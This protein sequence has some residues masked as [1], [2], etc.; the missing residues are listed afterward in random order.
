MENGWKMKYGWS[1]A[2]LSRAVRA[3]N[4]EKLITDLSSNS[5][6]SERIGPRAYRFYYPDLNNIRLT[7]P[8]SP[9][10]TDA[11]GTAHRVEILRPLRTFVSHFLLRLQLWLWPIDV[12]PAVAA[13]A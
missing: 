11:A 3:I 1:A 9:A 8:T 7:P 5:R 2:L 12:L 4:S 6:L 13:V 10:H